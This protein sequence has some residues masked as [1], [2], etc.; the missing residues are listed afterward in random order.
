M[1]HSVESISEQIRNRVDAKF[2]V[3]LANLAE[4]L[5]YDFMFAP[6]YKI[7]HRYDPPWDCSGM[8]IRTNESI[9]ID[10]YYSV[11]DF[12]D[13]CTGQST[14]SYT[15]GIGFLHNSF[16]E[17]Y[18]DMIREFVFECYIEVLSE[19][20]D[21][22]LVQQLLENGY[23][24]A[25]VE[26]NNI[27]QTVTDYELFEE[28]FWYHYE[29]IERVK[30]LSLKMMIARGK[31]EAIKTYHHQL[32]RWMEEEGKISFEQKGAQKLWNKLQKLFRLQK[33]YPLPKIEMK[34]YKTFQEFLDHN[35]ISIEERIILAK[36]MDNKFSNKVC[37]CLRNGQ[38]D[39]L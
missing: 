5:A 22:L 30:P 10:D 19:I 18:Q 12:F 16:E 38:G 35:R 24:I 13:E 27:I 11:E 20:D 1:K 17:K 28:P 29:I 31:N 7:T 21:N 39:Q 6:K 14:A 37:M 2:S 3:L 36:Y 34:D 32:V 9:S 25:E 8:L 23:D 33:G 15:S 4:E 26:R